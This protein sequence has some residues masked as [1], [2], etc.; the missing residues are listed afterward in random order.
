[1]T[2]TGREKKMTKL[3]FV[4]DDTSA[5]RWDEGAFGS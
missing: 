1:M 3:V 4:I 2:Q 5:T